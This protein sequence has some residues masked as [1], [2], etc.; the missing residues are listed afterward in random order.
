MIES[1]F[2]QGMASMNVQFLADVVSMSFYG[3]YT[4]E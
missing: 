2:H 3:A 1:E 4:N